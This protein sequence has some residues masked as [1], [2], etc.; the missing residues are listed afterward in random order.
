VLCECSREQTTSLSNSLT[1]EE[2]LDQLQARFKN[3]KCRYELDF[4]KNAKQ[5]YM[6]GCILHPYPI[7]KAVSLAY[8]KMAG[9][10]GSSHI[11]RDY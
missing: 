11:S 6:Y 2:R 9:K 7:L 5:Q 8:D 4:F 3:K 10:H 1:Y